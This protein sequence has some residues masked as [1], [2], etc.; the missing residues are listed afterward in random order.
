MD[1]E[2]NVVVFVLDFAEI[3]GEDFL[4]PQITICHLDF[5]FHLVYQQ[6]LD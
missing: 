4:L 1:F 6:D 5:I 2:Q 3:E